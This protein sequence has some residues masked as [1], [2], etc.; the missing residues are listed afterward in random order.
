MAIIISRD[1][2]GNAASA[3]DVLAEA[4]GDGR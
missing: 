2:D 4:S 3:V 1:E